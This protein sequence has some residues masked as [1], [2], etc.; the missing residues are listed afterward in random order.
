[1]KLR[2]LMIFILVV[3]TLVAQ[4]QAADTVVLVTHDS[5]AISESLLD[6]F[7]AQT[8][9]AVEVLRAGDAGQMVNQAILSKNNPLGDV[10]YG[11]D[12]TFLS[13]ALAGE[14]FAAYQSPALDTVAAQFLRD[15]F[16]VTP[17][18]FGDV[19]LNYDIA[20]FEE[21][22]LSLPQSLAELADEKYAGLL[23][24]QNPATSSP[25]LAFLLA[26][27]AN[28]GEADEG[29]Y[30]DYWAALRAND[31]LV[32]DGWTDAYYGEFTIGS[33]GAGTRPLVVSYASSP[34]AEVIYAEDPS[35]G[36]VTGA[37]IEDGMCFRQVEY[38]G[39]LQGSANQA[40]AQLL[41]DFMLSAEFQ[42]DMPLNMFVFPVVEGTELPAEFVEYAQVPAQPAFVAP[43][44]IEAKREAWIQAWAEAMLR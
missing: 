19:C 37:L 5:F 26:T 2:M 30:L 32:A 16:F 12:N 4:A 22:E 35:A 24:V 34:P 27:I 9:L 43:A 8:G 40:G 36:A 13:R 38:V 18:D 20:W 17:V 44:D 33:R 1:M 15:D 23:A 6:S 14:I 29:G 3:A 7:E 41:I 11:V 39:A 10:L 21:N 28:F 31:V 42:A 25:G